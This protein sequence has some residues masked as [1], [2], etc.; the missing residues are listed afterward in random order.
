MNKNKFP[1]SITLDDGKTVR[2]SQ[3]DPKKEIKIMG[4]TVK[5]E[6]IPLVAAALK[7]GCYMRG[8]ALKEKDIIFCEKHQTD[9]TVS[10]VIT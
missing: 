1:D 10:G 2:L 7:C 8:I 4:R 5:V 9:T 6:D 3:L